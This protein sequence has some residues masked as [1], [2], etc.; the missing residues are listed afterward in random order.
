MLQLMLKYIT[1][2]GITAN[3]NWGNYCEYNS[4]WSC[5]V[6]QILY[7]DK[8]KVCSKLCMHANLHVS[9]QEK[10]SFWKVKLLLHH[11]L[12]G[13]SYDWK[14]MPIICQGSCLFIIKSCSCNQSQL[15]TVHMYVSSIYVTN[16]EVQ[17]NILKCVCT[18]HCSKTHLENY[19]GCVG[20]NSTRN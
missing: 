13:S 19:T 2:E 20:L 14:A 12:Y 9:T 4:V 17:R 11:L 6:S 16:N 1:T 7:L 15:Y 18:V 10:F 3:T 8:M 5:G